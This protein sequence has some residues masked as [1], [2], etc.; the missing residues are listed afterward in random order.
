[1]V[2]GGSQGR[3]L[4]TAKKTKK[5]PDLGPKAPPKKKA[6]AKKK[7][8]AKAKESAKGKKAAADEKV[9]EVDQKLADNEKMLKMYQWSIKKEGNMQAAANKRVIALR[10]KF[11]LAETKKAKRN[12]LNEILKNMD[13]REAIK[14]ALTNYVKKFEEFKKK[15]AEDVKKSKKAHKDQDKA[16]KVDP[17][18]GKKAISQPS[19]KELKN[20][21]KIINTGHKERAKLWATHWGKKVSLGA[22]TKDLK[23]TLRLQACIMKKCGKLQATSRQPCRAAC[24]KQWS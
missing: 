16:K 22:N 11:K 12:L 7:P 1:M 10:I 18:T 6:D 2:D 23:V 15:V 5:K 4:A 24:R 20:M 8:A 3:V 19:Q 9:K 14:T 13:R 17:K 21:Q